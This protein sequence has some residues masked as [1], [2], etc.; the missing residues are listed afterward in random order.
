M[1]DYGIECV[2]TY[3]NWAFFRK[4]AADGPFE[5]YS[6]YESKVDHCKR[7]AYL[8]GTVGGVN[9][10]I[11]L[12]N[13]T[14]SQFNQLLSIAGF[15][16]FVLFIPIFISYQRKIKELKKEQSLYDK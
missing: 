5:I 4:K 7:V 16:I 2:D 12:F 9:L 10:F 8:L 1:K 6:D 11:A 14:L 13:M 15:L 3:T